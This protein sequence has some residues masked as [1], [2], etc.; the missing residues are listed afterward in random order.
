MATQREDTGKP[1][2]NNP[3]RGSSNPG[4]KDVT[5]TGEDSTKSGSVPGGKQNIGR[6]Q[7]VGVTR[8]SDVMKD[9]DT[10]GAPQ[11]KRGES[12][13]G[14]QSDETEFPGEDIPEDKQGL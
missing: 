2:Q 6:D 5:Q 1:Q 14:Q 9:K 4:T 7:E 11:Q 13:S 10:G 3:D 8:R 12:H